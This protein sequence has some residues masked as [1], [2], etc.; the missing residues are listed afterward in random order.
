MAQVSKQVTWSIQGIVSRSL[1]HNS[2]PPATTRSR[3]VHDNA[4]SLGGPD[5]A[6]EVFPVEAGGV[7][8]SFPIEQQVLMDTE[9]TTN[10]PV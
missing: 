9:D 2:T 6:C 3:C 7:P 10:C 8:L 5:G 4:G 1:P